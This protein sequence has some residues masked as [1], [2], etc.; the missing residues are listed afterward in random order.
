MRILITVLFL[1]IFSQAAYAEWEL[2][3]IDRADGGV[4]IVNY[5]TEAN[6]T[7]ED[8]I[9]DM[10]FAGR[11]RVSITRSD[12]PTDRSD[13]AHW[14]IQ[15]NRVVVDQVKK[16]AAQAAEAQK[17]GKKNAALAKLGITGQELR[18]LLHGE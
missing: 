10:G 5:N 14:K 2:H 8:V 7:L 4:T 12:I 15:G 16:A 1:F 3:A 13:R 6:D 11:P 9:R 18:E 17:E